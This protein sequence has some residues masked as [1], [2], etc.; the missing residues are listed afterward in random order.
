M[1]QLHTGLAGVYSQK[2]SVFVFEKKS[3][4]S[5]FVKSDTEFSFWCCFKR[6]DFK[7]GLPWRSYSVQLRRAVWFI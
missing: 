7:F 5:I 6:E 2:L 4:R 1:K 3:I